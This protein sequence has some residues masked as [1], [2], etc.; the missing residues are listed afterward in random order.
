[1]DEKAVQGTGELGDAD[2]SRVVDQLHV[3]RKQLINLARSNRLLYF[4]A[5]RRSTLEIVG[6]PESFASVVA[7][8][9]AGN[10]W[11]FYTPPPDDA[12][13]GDEAD[14]FEEV[15][16]GKGLPVRGHEAAPVRGP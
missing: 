2:R 11:R 13:G 14:A 5:T 15:A 12:A 16:A 3:W 10:S 6:S 9:R 1:M 7:Q 4:R 8:L